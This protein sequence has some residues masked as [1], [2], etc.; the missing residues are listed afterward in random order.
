[1][2]RAEDAARRAE[3]AAA[4][5]RLEATRAQRMIDDF[6]AAARAEQIPTVPLEARLLSGQLVRTDR[7]G[8][9]LRHNRSIAIGEDG[10][11]Y[12]LV[13]PGGLRERLRGIHLQPSPP[14]LVVGRGGKDGESGDL[15]SF[16]DRILSERTPTP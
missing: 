16:L 5:R 3:L 4:E 14:P 8:W 6:L 1:V 7:R 15:R 11:Y 12:Q 9:Y 2:A 13:V 10:G